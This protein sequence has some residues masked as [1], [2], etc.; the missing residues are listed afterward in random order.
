[1]DESGNIFLNNEPAWSAAARGKL[2]STR[3]SVNATSARIVS[4]CSALEKNEVIPVVAWRECAS[5]FAW[6]LCVLKWSTRSLGNLNVTPAQLTKRVA[7][8]QIWLNNTRI[9]IRILWPELLCVWPHID[10]RTIRICAFHFIT[11]SDVTTQANRKRKLAR[12]CRRAMQRNMHTFRGLSVV[13]H[14]CSVERTVGNL[15]RS[16]STVK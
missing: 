5:A 8:S 1:M 12:H 7:I 16:N 11:A 4:S 13:W 3:K 14:Y 9:F 2:C 10:S 6:C 15:A